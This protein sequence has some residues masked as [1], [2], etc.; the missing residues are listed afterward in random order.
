MKSSVTANPGGQSA[1]MSPWGSSTGWQL[2]GGDGEGGGEGEISAHGFLRKE[3]SWVLL[4]A[5]VH[6]SP[7]RISQW[8]LG[9]AYGSDVVS[10]PPHDSP[11]A[12]HAALAPA[13]LPQLLQPSP[14]T[15]PL[16]YWF[17]Q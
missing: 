16:R 1:H 4:F 17:G 10:T 6:V 8:P 12:T 15:H 14:S 13:S 2:G 7:L 3:C 5:V 9:L 11:A